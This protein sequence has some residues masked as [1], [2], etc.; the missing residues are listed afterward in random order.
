MYWKKA[1]DLVQEERC[2]LPA[3]IESSEKSESPTK[4]PSDKDMPPRK[5][6]GTRR[7]E[8][9]A[10][11]EPG[12]EKEEDEG[13]GFV[14]PSRQ[15]GKR[16]V[17]KTVSPKLTTVF[18]NKFPS[19]TSDVRVEIIA[20]LLTDAGISESHRPLHSSKVAANDGHRLQFES[21][22]GPTALA[23][24][25]SPIVVTVDEIEYHLQLR[26]D[27]AGSDFSA[28]NALKCAFSSFP[29]S[30][31]NLKPEECFDSPS[32]RLQ[33]AAKHAFAQVLPRPLVTHVLEPQRPGEGKQTRLNVRF[34]F[35]DENDAN[36]AKG[37]GLKT[38]GFKLPALLRLADVKI[39]GAPKSWCDRCCS[40][41]HVAEYCKFEPCCAICGHEGHDQY[42]EECPNPSGKPF[43]GIC[44]VYGHAAGDLDHC[45]A[46]L[47]PTTQQR[48]TATRQRVVPT[49]TQSSPAVQAP[50]SRMQAIV[51]SSANSDPTNQTQAMASYVLIG[52]A[53]ALLAAAPPPADPLM[54]AMVAF[55]MMVGQLLKNMIQ[56]NTGIK[57]DV[58]PSPTTRERIAAIG[59][60]EAV[61]QLSSH[62][63]F[64]ELGST[65]RETREH[66][67]SS[68]ADKEEP[69][70]R[71]KSETKSSG[72]DEM[73]L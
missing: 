9:S 25:D 64:P 26:F 23:A 53:T 37:R 69:P 20:Q 15:L 18:V 11:G 4:N 44:M 50:P 73:E 47:W 41:G 21:S 52:N 39:P 12:A 58:A 56:M 29:A 19:V 70:K 27:D 65:P 28:E 7:S 6:E 10:E 14:P 68:K 5:P 46:R 33:T 35:A 63:A 24:L 59:P 32:E 22:H 34:S 62:T 61:V 16:K 45:P 17:K 8:E 72:Q 67:R 71:Q 36:L 54:Q 30:F 40:A 43:C 31:L 51:S 60:Q 42:S 66:A 13:W 2:F 3:L 38:T 55:N 48:R 49:P 1:R 57:P